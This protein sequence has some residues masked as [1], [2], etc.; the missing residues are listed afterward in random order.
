MGHRHTGSEPPVRLRGMRAWTSPVVPR[1][2]VGTAGP[3][4]LHDTSTDAVR[5]TAPSGPAPVYGCGITPDDATHMGPPATHLPLHPLQRVRPGCTSA[6]SR[7][8]TRRTWATL[9]PTSPSTF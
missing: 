1:L 4:R 6:A 3:V 7:R 5:A 8:T 9:P 2:G